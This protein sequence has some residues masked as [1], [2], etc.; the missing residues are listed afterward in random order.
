MSTPRDAVS[1]VSRHGLTDSNL[2]VH[3]PAEVRNALDLRKGDLI[4]WRI[5]EGY[6]EMSKLV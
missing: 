3:I 6:V 5:R 1:R 2:G 4:Y